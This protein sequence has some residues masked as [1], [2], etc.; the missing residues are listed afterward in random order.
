MMVCLKLLSVRPVLKHQSP[1]ERRA[2]AANREQRQK[3]DGGSDT[4]AHQQRS[5]PT[6]WTRSAK[7]RSSA[8][9]WTEY[10]LLHSSHV[11]EVQGA[12]G[13]PQSGSGSRGGNFTKTLWVRL[14]QRSPSLAVG[15]RAAVRHHLTFH[16][17]AEAPVAAEFTCRGHASPLSPRGPET[18]KV[19]A[20]SPGTRRL[21][22]SHEVAT[23]TKYQGV[24]STKSLPSG[25]TQ[26]L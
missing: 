5:P 16:A 8:T 3:Q 15:H 10:R 7:W 23:A 1:N 6:A 17:P 12:S 25:H 24:R 26:V 18:A 14:R 20:P 11:V 19:G 22:L 9:A 2:M 21:K 13:F 4:T